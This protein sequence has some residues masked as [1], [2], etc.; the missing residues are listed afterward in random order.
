MLT[1][2]HRYRSTCGNG[3]C[4]ISKRFV[5][6]LKQFRGFSISCHR[7]S[8]AP[9]DIITAWKCSQRSIFST[10]PDIGW[11]KGIKLRSVWKITN[12]CQASN[13]NML[14]PI[15][16]IKVA[17]SYFPIESGKSTH[18]DFHRI[19]V[20]RSTVRIY[21]ATTSTVNGSTSRKWI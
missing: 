17:F 15:S 19:Q 2:G 6:I 8:S 16:E 9:I 14:A 1:F 18:F 13:P 7:L 4:V 5:E 11:P 21:I 10:A 20:L 3:T 12:A